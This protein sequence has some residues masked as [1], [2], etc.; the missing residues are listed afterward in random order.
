MTAGDYIAFVA[1][2]GIGFA[3]MAE[4]NLHAG[5]AWGLVAFLCL[6]CAR[7]Y[8]QI[9]WLRRSNRILRID[10]ASICRCGTGAACSEN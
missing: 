6:M 2:A 1:A 7:Y 8:A 10:A 9:R 3:Y 4:G 5:G